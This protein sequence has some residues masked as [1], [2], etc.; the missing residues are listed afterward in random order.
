MDVTCKSSERSGP[1]FDV[2]READSGP[3]MR[4]AYS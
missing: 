3:I 4:E 1:S 2:A